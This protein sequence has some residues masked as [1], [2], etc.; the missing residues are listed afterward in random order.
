MCST[1]ASVADPNS[2]E[3]ETVD[4]SEFKF[5]FGCNLIDDGIN[6]STPYVVIII[7]RSTNQVITEVRTSILLV[8][9]HAKQ[10]SDTFKIYIS[11]T[12]S[13]ESESDQKFF[14]RDPN[15]KKN[16]SDPQHLRKREKIFLP[17]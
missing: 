3:S 9:L 6:V 14:F 16:N 10:I 13:V 1:Q 15:P 4:G 5:G 11:F 12:T 8:H 2:K 17:C 7:N